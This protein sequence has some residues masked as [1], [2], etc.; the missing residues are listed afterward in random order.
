MAFRRDPA[1]WLYR[2]SPSEWLRAG[3]NELERSRRAFESR[4]RP[5]AI[6]GL[7]RAAGMSLNAV[8]IEEPRADWGRSYVDHLRAAALEQSLPE[9]VRNAARLVVDTPMPS[10]TIVTLSTRTLDQRLLEAAETVMA[11]AYAV[12]HGSAAHGDLGGI[13][14][15]R[16]P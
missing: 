10:A 16:K 2:L 5:A 9:P 3:L 12:V 4:Q 6:A 14:D 15:E 1:H 7:K 11:H 8:L 13:A